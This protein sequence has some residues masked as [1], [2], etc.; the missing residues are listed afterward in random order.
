MAETH[1][2]KAQLLTE[3]SG[4]IWDA[5]YYSSDFTPHMENTWEKV[6]LV[7]KQI[8]SSLPE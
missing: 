6:L 8:I 4:F 7:M 3:T 5:T 1:H 2:H